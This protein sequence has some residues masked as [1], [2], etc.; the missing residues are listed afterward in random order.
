MRNRRL[1]EC[2]R[3][4][5]RFPLYEYLGLAARALSALFL[6]QVREND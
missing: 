6:R 4:A 1:R 2:L 5:G 3:L